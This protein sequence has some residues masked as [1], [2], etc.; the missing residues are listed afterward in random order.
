MCSIKWARW[1]AC[2]NWPPPQA[3]F[4]YLHHCCNWWQMVSDG[5]VTFLMRENSKTNSFA[6]HCPSHINS[7]HHHLV[8]SQNSDNGDGTHI[9]PIVSPQIKNRFAF[10]VSSRNKQALGVCCMYLSEEEADFHNYLGALRLLASSG[11]LFKQFPPPHTHFSTFRSSF[12]ETSEKLVLGTPLLN[13]RWR[14]PLES[15]LEW[16]CR[17]D[18][19]IFNWEQFQKPVVSALLGLSTTQSVFL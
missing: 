5:L 7:G 11:E 13:S 19:S 15:W 14:T 6:W 4:L 17:P 18:I 9:M 2:Q 1:P 12:H 3:S 10:L 8:A 16:R